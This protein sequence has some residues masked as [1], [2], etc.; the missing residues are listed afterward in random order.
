M[1]FHK[2]LP[3]MHHELLA[4]AILIVSGETMLSKVTI[5]MN[6]IYKASLLTLYM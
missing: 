1:C 6:Y 3:M 2:L 4:V 5:S